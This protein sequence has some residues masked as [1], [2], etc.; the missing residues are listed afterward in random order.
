MRLVWKNLQQKVIAFATEAHESHKS[1]WAKR[2]NPME[3]VA[4]W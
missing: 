3:T 2:N 4:M 1:K